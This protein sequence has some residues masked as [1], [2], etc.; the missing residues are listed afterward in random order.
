MNS[1]TF[2][3]ISSILLWCGYRFYGAAFG[4]FLGVDASRPTPA[5]TKYDGVDYVPVKHWMVLFGHHFS[6]IAGAGP[7]VGPVIAVTFW[8]WGPATLFVILGSILVGGVHDFGALFLSVRYGGTSISEISERILSRTARLIFSWFVLLALI[9]VVAVF[10]YLCSQTFVI[11]PKIVLPSLGLIPV[12]LAFGIMVYHMR[13]NIAL[14]TILGLAA[15]VSLVFAGLLLPIVISKGVAMAVWIIVLLAYCA[16]ASVLP[17]N[18]LLQPRDYLASY[19][20]FFGIIVGFLGVFTAHPS[21][22][23]PFYVSWKTQEGYLWPMLF[24]TVACGAISGFHSLIAAGT[25]SKQI[26]SERDLKRIGFGAMIVEAVVAVI[27]IAAVAGGFKDFSSMTE[28]VTKSGPIEAYG[29]GFGYLTRFILGNYG[30]FIAIITLNAFILT[31]LDAA[32]RI[33]R[34]IL[35]EIFKGID[36]YTATIIIVVVSGWVAF[37]G[38][39]QKIWPIFGSANQLI[40]ALTLIVLSSWCLVQKKHIRFTFIPAVFMLITTLASLFLQLVLYI[41]EKNLFLLFID[42]VLITLAVAMVVDVYVCVRRL[43]VKA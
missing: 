34:Y 12:A 35:Q 17:V 24:V 13:V 25:S 6:A 22:T 2:L 41:K 14:A 4:K 10:V 8:G 7:I 42:I 32:T 40:A 9:V 28:T 16:V 31:T 26:S 29:K 3:I 1:L 39:W 20:L 36:R 30:G 21:F 23:A 33:T 38:S 37:S 11:E 15:L 27:A 19:M 5:H 43:K 18:I